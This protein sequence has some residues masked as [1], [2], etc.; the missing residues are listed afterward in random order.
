MPRVNGLRSPHAKVGRIVYFGR[1]IDK[2]RLHGRGVLAPEYQANLGDSKPN[3]FDARC[4][5]FLRAS[6][7]EITKLPNFRR[8]IERLLDGTEKRRIAL[9][10][11]EQD[12]LTCHRTILICRELANHAVTIMHIVRGGALETHEHAEKRLI[13]E[14]FGGDR[15][16]D[17]FAGAPSAEG[18]LNEAYGVRGNRIAYRR[19][20]PK[21]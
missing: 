3:M 11:A 8:G 15:Q 10:C 4:C 16:P 7:E 17:L 9:M 18:R 2:I 14:E 5:R 6:Y 19:D 21:D 13:A 1:M 12:P 20:A